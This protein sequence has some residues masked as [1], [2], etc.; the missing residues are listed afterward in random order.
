MRKFKDVG[1]TQKF[2]SSMGSILNLL[3]V[4]RYKNTAAIYKQKLKN[5]LD[6]FENI[7]NTM[8]NYA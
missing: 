4:G 3:K 7:V 2:L 5:A 1:S 6:I 8:D